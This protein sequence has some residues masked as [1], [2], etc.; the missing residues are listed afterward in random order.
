[1][2]TALVIID[3]QNC[4][5]DYVRSPLPVPGA[6]SDIRRLRKFISKSKHNLDRIVV[7]YDNHPYDHI[8]H[9][10]RWIDAEDNH[11]TSFTVITC[12]DMRDGV[13]R[14]ANPDD[15]EWQLEYLRLL[16][17]P[18]VIWPVHGQENEWEA[19]IQKGLL[20]TLSF[21]HDLGKPCD[22]YAKGMHRDTEQFGIF[23]AEVPYPGVPETDINHE[24]IAQIDEYDTVIF[25]GEAS[26]HCVM[27][28][29][30]QFIDYMPS[31]DPTKVVLLTDCMSPVPG[32]AEVAEGWLSEMDAVGVRLAKSTENFLYTQ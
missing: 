4:F 29:V 21:Y 26:S 30:K 11:P 17:R 18:H 32:F 14:A 10:N 25:A 15:Q 8:S 2:K 24:L 7:S 5:M 6:R 3:P 19:N 1:M 23:G 28:S 9:A 12:D 27:D 20:S 31:Q 16:K 13:W 22:Y